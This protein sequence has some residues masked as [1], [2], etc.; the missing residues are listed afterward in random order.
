MS[1]DDESKSRDERNIDKDNPDFADD[2]DINREVPIERRNTLQRIR[3]DYDEPPRGTIR[4]AIQNSGDA[5]GRNR[6]EGVLDADAELEITIWVDSDQR[7]FT[8]KDNAGGMDRETFEEN[9]F[10]ID[11]PDEVKEAGGGLGAYGRGFHVVSMSGDGKTY[12]ETRHGDG[13]YASTITNDGLYSEPQEPD[14]S[15]LPEDM[16]GTYIYVADVYEHDMVKFQNW[17][18]VEEILLESFTMLLAR[19]DVTLEYIIDGEVHRA[20][21]PD[22]RQYIGDEDAQLAYRKELP[23]FSAEGG[24]YQIRDLYVIRTDAIDEEPPWE[25]IAMMKSG[26]YHDEPFMTVNPYK[27]QNIPSLRSPPKMIGW[28]DASNLCPDLEDNSHSTFRG[29]ETDAGIRDIVLDLH[30]EH[31]K[32]GRSTEERQELA[33]KITESINELLVEYDDFDPYQVPN[34]GFEAEQD[35]D[36]GD[37]NTKTDDDTSIIKCQAGSREFDVGEEIPLQIL[38][39]NPKDAEHERYELHDVQVSSNNLGF[40]R[41]LSSRVI[42]VPAND[43]QTFDVRTFR[44]TEEGVYSF[45]AKIRPQPE[46]MG[47]EEEEHDTIDSSRVYFY[48]GDVEPRSRTTTDDNGDEDDVEDDEGGDGD[49]PTRV[50]VVK[51]TTLYPGDDDSWKAVS[52]A[53]EDGGIDVIINTN[54]PE[55]AS[56]MGITDNDERRDRVQLRLGTEWGIEEVI[57]YRNVDEIHD[58]LGNH[59]IDGENTAEKLAEMLTR[60]NGLLA[61][62]ESTIVTQYG[63]EYES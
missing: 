29:H 21:A 26:D 45:S 1:T 53:R 49:Q 55:W 32:K 35:G 43:H 56:A 14:N 13:H 37:G 40:N 57:L 2:E 5:W 61:Q 30:K 46:V 51:D 7:T 11:T 20:D 58:L 8:Y 28:C 16:Q 15:R 18:W 6:E 36:E 4:E 38:V 12:V 24:T 31:F 59:T 48:V 42:D 54:R 60:R 10:G 52:E 47:M 22:L 63:A 19:D 25:G 9:L 41:S 34:D 3:E 33:S 44:P 27:P 23:E 17:D 62:M 39:E 50:S